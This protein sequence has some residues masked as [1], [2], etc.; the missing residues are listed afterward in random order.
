MISYKYS[1]NPDRSE[2]LEKIKGLK[3][4]DIGGATSFADGHLSAIVDFNEPLADYKDNFFQG[5]INMP[6]VW[7]EISYHV[8]CNGRFNFAIC[9][10][11]LEDISNPLLVCR[12]MEKI[13][14]AGFIVVPSKY[15]ELARL[16]NHFRGFIHHRW[17]FDIIDGKFTGFPKVNLIEHPRFDQVKGDKGELQIFWEGEIGMEIINNDWL[18]PDNASVE[19][20]YDKLL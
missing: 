18:G 11:T 13:A 14:M 12:Q 6:E 7:E 10:H 2:V 8:K 5:N 4:I 15:I 19:S 17:I 3:V 20:Y 9:T 16:G 1:N